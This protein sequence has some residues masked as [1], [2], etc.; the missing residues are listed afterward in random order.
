MCLVPIF[1]GKPTWTPLAVSQWR[2][3][4]HVRQSN[5]IIIKCDVRWKRAGREI[6]PIGTLFTTNP[7][8]TGLETNLG[9]QGEGSAIEKF[10]ALGIRG[11]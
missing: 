6:C 3:V 5:V 7:T 1:E 10:F 11:H 8:W 4:D 2:L 9:L